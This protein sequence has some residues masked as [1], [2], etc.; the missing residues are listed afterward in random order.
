M[1]TV[2]R[3]AIPAVLVL[4]LCAAV[5]S[6]G[7]TKTEVWP[8]GRR[9]S[10]WGRRCAC[11]C[12]PTHW[13]A[14]ASWTPGGTESDSEAE[15]GVHLDAHAQADRPAEAPHSQLG[16]R[17]VPVGA[18]RLRL[19]LDTGRP[20]GAEPREPRDRRV[21]ARAAFT[22]AEGSGPSIERAWTCGTRT[23][24][25]PR[26]TGSASSSSARS[27]SSGMETVPYVSAEVLYDTRYDAWSEQRYQVGLEMIL[28]A[29]WHLEPYY[30]RQKDHRA[31]SRSTRTH[32]G[33]VLKYHH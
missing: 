17:A 27:R 7:D 28:D 2:D 26:G 3:R 11:T 23:A 6:A 8:E 9:S 25:T 14:P 18:G 19:P 31:P 15:T 32:F 16:A 29:R 1:M 4:T 22:W 10:S 30:L 20:G 5:I 12:L 24:R 13:Y 33:L 21:P